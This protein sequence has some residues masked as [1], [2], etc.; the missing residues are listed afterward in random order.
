MADVVGQRSGASS[1]QA[2]RLRRVVAAFSSLPERYL[3][4]EDDLDAAVH[5]RLGDI[6][7]TWEVCLSGH[8][9]SVRTSPRRDPDVVIGTDAATWLALR[10][11]R[12]SGV[13]AFAQGRLYARGNLDLALG[14]EGMFKLPGD[15]P[16][17]VR[18]H[19]V[20]IAGAT[21][22]TLTAGHGPER[23]ICLHG[24]GGNKTSFFSTVAALTPTHTVHSIDLPGF[25]SSSKPARAPYDAAYFARSVR[26]FMDALGISRAHLV[27]NSMGG[28]VA[29]E[30]ALADPGRVAS[31]GLLAPAL[32]WRRG[33]ELAPLVRLLRPELAAIPHALRQARVRDQLLSLFAHPDRLDP[34]VA[35]IACDEFC[36]TYRS[37]AA[38]IAFYAAAR[39]I[40]LDAPWGERGFWTRLRRLQ[41]PA[42]FVWGD[43]DRLVPAGFSHHVA[44]VL[45]GAKQAVL[46]DCG[47]VPQ[48]ELPDQTNALLTGLISSAGISGVQQALAHTA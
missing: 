28:R 8:R 44:D 35:D 13:D 48:I 21:I 32:A 1:L 7:R 29:I 31:L 20:R 2:E 11:G 4:G 12:M 33:R 45:P 38:R 39:N 6:G 22:S 23:V 37:L 36:R 10:E 18:V 46:P 40:Y 25:G 15:R 47:H 16:P 26:R 9:C 14:F 24:L 17:M 19:D 30:L 42:L 34:A 27:G 3:G 41:P 43:H 5:I